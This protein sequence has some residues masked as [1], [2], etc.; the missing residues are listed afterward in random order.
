M[1]I[2][3][4]KTF[5]EVVKRRHFGKAADTLCITQSA[6]SARIK[7]LESQL[8]LQLLVRHRKEIQLTPAGHRLLRH[9][10]TIVSG[11]ERARQEMALAPT[12]SSTLAVGLVQDLWHIL[13][14]DWVAQMRRDQPAIA[15]HIETHPGETLVHRLTSHL[16]DLAFMFE[17]PMMPGL[18]TEQVLKIPLVLVA[19]HPGLSVAE[20]MAGGYLLVDWGSIFALRHA[21][22]FADLPAPAVKVN[23][24]M[25]ALDLLLTMGGS[26]YLSQR[27]AQSH[28]DRERLFLVEDAP[29]IER[30]AFAVYSPRSQRLETIRLLLAGLRSQV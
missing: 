11:W 28:V 12:F 18:E 5:L 7:L 2:A 20:A 30:F 15:L 6:V 10:E 4:L 17:P 25:L 1:D 24:G 8:G 9:A 27:M 19:S 26:A 23:A 21:E 3:L 13:P 14:R 29:V 16:L 22:L